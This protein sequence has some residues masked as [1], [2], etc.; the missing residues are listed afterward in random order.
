M[1]IYICIYIYIFMYTK[2][3]IRICVY[4]YR[5][6]RDWALRAIRKSP[7]SP[8]SG[9]SLASPANDQIPAQNTF[10]L[11]FGPLFGPRRPRTAHEGPKS[12]QDRPQRP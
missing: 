5:K 10:P 3:Y 2:D 11:G 6:N 1:Y 4:I 7:A 12:G 8:A 9:A